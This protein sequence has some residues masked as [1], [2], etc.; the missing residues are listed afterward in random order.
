MFKGWFETHVFTIQR[1]LQQPRSAVAHT[2]LLGLVYPPGLVYPFGLMRATGQ[3][4]FARWHSLAEPPKRTITITITIPKRTA[5]V[6]GWMKAESKADPR[7]RPRGRAL[8][9]RARRRLLGF[10]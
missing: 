9:R 8:A 2:R 5:H 3:R 7:A 10:V 1:R 6:R 4:P